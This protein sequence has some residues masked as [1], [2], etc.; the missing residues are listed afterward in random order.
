MLKK[1]NTKSVNPNND[2]MREQRRCYICEGMFYVDKKINIEK[3]KIEYICTNCSN[4]I[5]VET[6]DNDVGFPEDYYKDLFGNQGG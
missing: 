3:N 6:I 1:T 4:V 5:W 2:N